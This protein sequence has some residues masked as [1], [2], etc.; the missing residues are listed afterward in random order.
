[1]E[2]PQ[3]LDRNG[4]TQDVT[5]QAQIATMPPRLELWRLALISALIATVF[6]ALLTVTRQQKGAAASRL[7]LFL[8]GGSLIGFLAYRW[9]CLRREIKDGRFSL[10]KYRDDPQRYIRGRFGVIAGWFICTIAIVIGACIYI[11]I[12]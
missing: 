4:T 5:S 8:F 6:L 1:M 3:A 11:A 10:D 2:K 7:A 9:C 12:N